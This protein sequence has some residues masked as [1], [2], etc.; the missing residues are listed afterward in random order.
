MVYFF[1]SWFTFFFNWVHFWT[2][3]DVIYSM[4]MLFQKRSNLNV[5]L[6]LF[7]SFFLT[8]LK[9]FHVLDLMHVCACRPFSGSWANGWKGRK[10]KVQTDCSC[11]PFLSLPQHCSQRPKGWKSAARPQPQHQ[12]CR[13]LGWKL[14]VYGFWETVLPFDFRTLPWV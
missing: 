12:N 2:S 7:S 3:L 9:S 14:N 10:K 5:F 1:Q 6:L 13:Y 11:S 8:F 4:Y